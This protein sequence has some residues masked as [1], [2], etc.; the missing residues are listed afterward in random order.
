MTVDLVFFVDQNHF[1][2]GANRFARKDKNVLKLIGFDRGVNEEA[3]FERGLIS[4]IFFVGII[5]L[6]DDKELS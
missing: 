1:V 6:G 5:D 3:D 4:A 2:A